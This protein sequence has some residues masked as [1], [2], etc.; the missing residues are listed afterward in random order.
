MLHDLRH[1]LR[2]LA[3]SPGYTVTVLLTLALGIGG[4]TAVFSVLRS[5][6]LRP[7]AWAPR[8]R[9]MMIAEGDSASNIRPASYPT[10]QDWRASTTAFQALAFVRGQGAL[11]KTPSGVE[12]LIGAYVSDDYFR[13]LPEPVAIGRGLEPSDFAPDAP[14]VAVISW[15]LWQRRFSGDRSVIGRSVT[16]GERKYAIVGVMPVDFMY[17]VWA[18]LWSP[19]S[20]ILATDPALQ[21]RGLH[22]D[23]RVVGRLRAGVD[24]AAGVQALSAVAAH[25]ADAY[26][27]ENG[28]WRRVAFQPVTTEI[29]GGSG[30]QLRLLTAAAVFVLLIACVNVAALALARAG[31][32]SRELAIRAALGGGRAALLRLLAAE[33]VVLGVVAGALGLAAAVILVRWLRTAGRD[34]LPRAGELAVEPLA[35]AAAVAL[36][37]ALVVSLGLVPALRHRGSLPSALREGAGSGR[38]AGRRRLRAALVVG[39]LTLALVLLTGAG[40]LLRSLERLERVRTGFDEDHLLAVPIMP[41]SPKY[42]SPE[43]ALQL[44]RDVA[45]AVAALPGVQSVALTNHVPLSG[46]SINTPVEVEGAV[47]GETDEALFREVDNGYFRTAGIPILRGRDFTA[48]DITHPGNAVLV[49]QA[50]A[51]RYWP[52]GDAIGKRITVRKSAQG[53]PEFGERVRA[54]IVGVVGNVR[55]YSLDTDFVPE[56][57]LPYTI[58]VWGWMSLVAR[59]RTDPSLMVPTVARVVRSVEPDLPL[60]GAR[61]G[62]GVYDLRSSLR[63]SL[64]YRRFITGLLGA[65]A[66]PAL[67]LAALGIYGVTAYLVTQRSH[68]LGIRMA[69]GAQRRNVVALV[70]G[71]GLRLAAVGVVLGGVGAALTTRWLRSELYETSATDPLT[72][73]LAAVVLTAIG[74]LAALLPARRAAAIDPARALQAE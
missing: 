41:T 70:L 64:T 47:A 58:T 3:R 62:S 25:L 51:A 48:E 23:S 14:A 40:L 4:T 37:V 31:A 57:Y 13:V 32:R 44:Y 73:M 45:A 6:I 68:E 15:P 59:T 24:S 46:A 66:L 38:G 55:H 16:L 56:V 54:T 65:F 36:A 30:P 26:P 49:N 20:V 7:L 8:E 50:L 22:T 60:E 74:A 72:F 1:A 27:A 43:R 17:P 34:L 53:R 19:I 29:L 21:Q 63:E 35:M 12:R 61:L 67:L 71:E 28:G 39:E 52:G 11:L 18:D 2:T 10:F 69:L 42:A 9:V 33:C 5:V